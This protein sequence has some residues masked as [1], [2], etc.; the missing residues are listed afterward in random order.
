M[1]SL[2]CVV[3]THLPN[4]AY[5]FAT[6]CWAKIRQQSTVTILYTFLLHTV[7]ISNYGD[8]QWYN[9]SVILILIL[10]LL[11]SNVKIIW[12]VDLQSTNL[13]SIQYRITDTQVLSSVFT[14][15]MASWPPPNHKN[16]INKP[17]DIWYFKKIILV[18]SWI[19]IISP[20]S[21]YICV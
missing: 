13:W 10:F 2:T 21:I 9:L 1:S 8:L 4:V 6:S 17:H 15:A 19:M 20:H 7:A 18:N 14:Q 3:S 12:Y 16:S 5:W 11:Q